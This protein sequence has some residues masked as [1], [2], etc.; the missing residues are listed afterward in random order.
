MTSAN[1]RGRYLRYS[2]SATR[3]SYPSGLIEGPPVH[4]S[5]PA[6]PCCLPA[7][8]RFTGCTPHEGLRQLYPLVSGRRASVSSSTEDSPRGL[9]R[10]LG[11]RVGLT[12]S[13]VRISYP[14]LSDQA[15]RRAGSRGPALGRVWAW[16]SLGRGSSARRLLPSGSWS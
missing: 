15:K 6:Y 2:A 1:V 7:L 16:R 12:P 10:T 13:R 3:T 4:P 14:P 11:K 9:G 8:G 5:E